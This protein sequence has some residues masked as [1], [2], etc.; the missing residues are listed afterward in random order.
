MRTA[1]RTLILLG[2][3][4]TAVALGSGCASRGAGPE[5]AAVVQDE[6]ARQA[7]VLSAQQGEGSRAALDAGADAAS[8]T[9]EDP[10]T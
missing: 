7:A 2:P 1:A 4:L 5:V 3:I 10:P 8:K 9:S 6:A